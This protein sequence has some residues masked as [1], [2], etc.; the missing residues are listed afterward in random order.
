MSYFEVDDIKHRHNAYWDYYNVH[1]YTK[2]P[3][4]SVSWN[5]SRG[6]MAALPTIIPVEVAT[7]INSRYQ[8]LKTRYQP[9]QNLKEIGLFWQGIKKTDNFKQVYLQPMAY[10]C[11]RQLRTG[12]N[13]EPV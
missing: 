1:G 12:Y 4:S 7:F 3:D 10:L 6:I 2:L 8:H 9:P 11:N 13:T 5:W